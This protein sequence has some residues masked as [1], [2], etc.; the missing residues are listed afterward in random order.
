MDSVGRETIRQLAYISVGDDELLSPRVLLPSPSPLS[1]SFQRTVITFE[2]HCIRLPSWGA[3]VAQSVKRPTSAR[4]R[5]RG[6][7]VRAPR[8]A[9]G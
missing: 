5:S 4:S 2:N 3:W 7:G 1:A 6:P 9:L 8:Q